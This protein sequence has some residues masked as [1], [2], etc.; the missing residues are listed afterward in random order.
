MAKVH[1][2]Q[3]IKFICRARACGRGPRG[4][5]K[6]P[7]PQRVHVSK[8]WG[9]TKFSVDELEN[10]VQKHSSCWMAVGS[11]MS[12]IMALRI[13]ARLATVPFNHAHHE[14]YFPVKKNNQE[15]EAVSITFL[16]YD[17]I[18]YNIQITEYF[19]LHHTR[20][21]PT[22]KFVLNIRCSSSSVSH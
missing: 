21:K 14:S 20:S 6:F 8:K 17:G 7:G 15:T 9:C 4:H 5:C 11:N 3:V 19:K 13:R 2:D 16:A 10:V 22:N 18:G 1:T 12:L